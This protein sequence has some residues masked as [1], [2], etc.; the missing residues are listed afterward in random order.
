[1]KPRFLVIWPDPDQH[2]GQLRLQLFVSSTPMDTGMPFIS[3][4]P[5]TEPLRYEYPAIK[6]LTGL[7]SF[8]IIQKNL[9]TKSYKG[10]HQGTQ[11]LSQSSTKDLNNPG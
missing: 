6:R 2:W 3:A 1:M 8:L 9:T 4:L 5:V 10:F 7:I 11:R